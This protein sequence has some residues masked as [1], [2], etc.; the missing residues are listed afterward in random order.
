MAKRDKLSDDAIQAF[1]L[2]H[3]GW[4]VRDTTVPSMSGDPARPS[5]AESAGPRALSRSFS[6][7]DY[8]SGIAFVVRLAFAAERRDHHPDLAVHWGKVRVDWSTHDA[9]GITEVDAEMAGVTETLYKGEE[10]R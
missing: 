6:F 3:P 4:T 7:N 8:A 2:G 5:G 10:P 1:L 9:G